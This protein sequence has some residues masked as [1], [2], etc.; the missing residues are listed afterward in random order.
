MQLRHG[1]IAADA[2]EL[3]WGTSPEHEHTRDERNSAATHHSSFG[4]EAS[5]NNTHIR[6][7]AGLQRASAIVA[8][9]QQTGRHGAAQPVRRRCATS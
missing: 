3:R 4:P 6:A 8:E 1:P 9:Y 7:I 2:M 5:G